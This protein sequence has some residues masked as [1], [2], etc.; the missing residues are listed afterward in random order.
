MIIIIIIIKFNRRFDFWDKCR[1]IK[2][3][4]KYLEDTSSY[5][6]TECSFD[7]P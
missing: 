3:G 2:L 6:L 1:L 7:E 4:R 5:S